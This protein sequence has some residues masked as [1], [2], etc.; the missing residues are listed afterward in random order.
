MRSCPTC[1]AALAPG[2]DQCDLCGTPVDAPLPADRDDPI[3]PLAPAPAVEAADTDTTCARCGHVNPSGSRYCN[4][5]GET[6]LA[7][8]TPALP[9]APEGGV[10]GERPPSDVGRRAFQLLGLAVAVVIAFYAI[11]ALSSRRPA[12]PA[13][14]G[15]AE[16]P[17]AGQAAGVPL[18]AG[19]APPLPEGRQAEADRFEAEGTAESLFEAGR[20]YL[21]A[22][23]Q[24]QQEEPEASR[25]WAHEALQ[26]FEQ[27]L[28]LE[29]DP[30]VRLA[31]AESASM[32]GTDPMRPIQEARTILA[33][34]STHPGANLFIGE[35][36]LMI[37][38]TE[39][40]IRAFETVIANT[41]PGEPAR[42]SAESALEFI[43]TQGGT[44]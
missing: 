2:A 23:F 36:R 24:S 19:P 35:R 9:P 5:C 22:A 12:P 4:R 10:S 18:P 42:A 13:D 7:V 27:S 44:P 14:A 29:D 3:A 20:Y 6:L 31:L 26:R 34:D 15:T 38:R 16:A 43:R 21:T 30:T 39:E 37:G 25:L 1:G 17:A 11:D 28:A 33:A 40:A 41:E 32:E 8:A